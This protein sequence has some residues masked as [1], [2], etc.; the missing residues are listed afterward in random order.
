MAKTTKTMHGARV[1]ASSSVRQAPK[2]AVRV[3]RPGGRRAK[4]PYSPVPT[5]FR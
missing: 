5:A 2:R 1:V 4:M 3:I